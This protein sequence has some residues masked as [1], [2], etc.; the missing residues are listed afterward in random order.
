MLAAGHAGELGHSVDIFE[1]NNISSLYAVRDIL[2][3][4]DCF[5]CEA[6]LYVPDDT[7]F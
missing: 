3:S 1:K 4:S 5:I 7:I 6:D 2:G